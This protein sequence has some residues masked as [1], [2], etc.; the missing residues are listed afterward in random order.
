MQFHH[1][2]CL[3]DTQFTRRDKHFLFD[4]LDE[5]RLGYFELTHMDNFVTSI[6]RMNK[7]IP[8]LNGSMQ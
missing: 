7:K 5:T 3:E 4:G 2:D 8:V 6:S 1:L